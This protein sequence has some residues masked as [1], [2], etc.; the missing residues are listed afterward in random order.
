MKLQRTLWIYPLIIF[1]FFSCNGKNQTNQINEQ[2]IPAEN[3]QSN[4]PN[5]I[6]GN[7][8][9]NISTEHT[10]LHITSKV[11]NNEMYNFPTIFAQ[12]AQTDDNDKLINHYWFLSDG[13]DLE[14]S[15]I[16]PIN[17][18]S[19]MTPRVY[20]KKLNIPSNLIFYQE[21]LR[22]ELF[23]IMY[24]TEESD[25]LYVPDN[26]LF[27]GV[28]VPE[29]SNSYNVLNK[30]DGDMSFGMQ[31][32]N[33]EQENLE[34]PLV[35]IWGHLPSLTEYRLVD[36]SNC[37]YYMVI[38]RDIPLFVVRRGAYFLKQINEN[39]YET[40]SSFPDGCLRFEI[41]NDRRILLTPLFPLPEDEDGLI[42]LMI[43]DRSPI[44]INEINEMDDEY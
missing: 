26:S 32:R 21:R 38:E 16:S 11:N 31:N 40:V 3:N 35:G 17:W 1:L 34:H 8:P 2:N 13:R 6:S 44:K 36:P 22:R 7:E 5:T 23:T 41:I 42:G 37:I 20:F 15:S 30:R 27:S 14:D 29:F 10:T 39:T 28:L 43:M 24:Q 18:V 12:T 25:A 33:G 9:N 4:L 19:F